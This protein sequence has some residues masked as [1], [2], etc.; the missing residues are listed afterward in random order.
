MKNG[1]FAQKINWPQAIAEVVLIIAG[2]LIALAVEGWWEDRQEREA[3]INYLQALKSDFEANRKSLE[4]AIEKQEEIVNAGDEVLNLIKGGL[5]EES[6]DEFFSKVG[7]TVYF[8]KNWTPVNGT[9]GD[10]ISSGRLL[11]V[12]NGRLRSELAE[13]NRSLE[14]TAQMEQL[15]TETFYAR[16]SPFLAKNQDVNHFTWS[17]IYKPPISPFSVDTAPFTTLEFWNLLV[18]WIYIHVDIISNYQSSLDRCDRILDLI[19]IEMANSP[20]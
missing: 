15:Q 6:S 20:N 7:N 10:L 5:D 16:Q 9:Y 12:R 1:L 19:E 8:F 11:Y 18:E 17:D 13:F 2:I 3:E 14:K 4:A